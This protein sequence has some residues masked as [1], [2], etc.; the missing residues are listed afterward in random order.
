MT[1]QNSQTKILSERK[2]NFLIFLVDEQRFPT[3]Y[4]DEALK[5]WRKEN[6]KTQ[7][8]L[9]DN[10]LEFLNHYI[11]STA[12]SPSRTTLYTG[13]YPSLHGVTK[14]TGGAANS[15]EPDIFWLD[16]NS[17][18]TIGN[19]FRTAGYDT[20]W[21]GKWHASHQDILIPG[22]QNALPSYHPV[23]GVPNAKKRKTISGSKPP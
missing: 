19:Y 9:R 11:G 7:E 22:T 21:K 5:K 14:T 18:P 15:S 2:P 4:E 12:C 16:P 17:V 8:L 10:G 23:N 13:Q 20:F 3:V 6:L 1:T